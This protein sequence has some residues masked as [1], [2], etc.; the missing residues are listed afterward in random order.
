MT[1]SAQGTGGGMALW[2][3]WKLTHLTF[4][5]ALFP[6]PRHQVISNPSL[7]PDLMRTDSVRSAGTFE[8]RPSTP[9]LMA[10]ET[11]AQRGDLSGQMPLLVRASLT[12]QG[13]S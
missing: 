6:R 12:V 2:P 1:H 3:T 5:P 11:G 8:M 13:F 4:P 9:Q 10:D 7:C